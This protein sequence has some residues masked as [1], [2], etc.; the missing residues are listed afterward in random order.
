MLV[1]NFLTPNFK[2]TKK[3]KTTKYE[4][5]TKKIKITLSQHRVIT[6]SI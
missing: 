5:C 3:Q 1:L 6:F 4:K 2:Q